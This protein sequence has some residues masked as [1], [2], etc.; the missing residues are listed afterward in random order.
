MS[1][2]PDF[3]PFLHLF[4]L[5]KLKIWLHEIN[6]WLVKND[7]KGQNLEKGK[8][9]CSIF[10]LQNFRSSETLKKQ[11][12]VLFKSIKFLIWLSRKCPKGWKTGH[13]TLKTYK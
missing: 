4:C 7:W 2:V 3:A 10:K 11:M 8:F 13:N 6:I 5:S 12:K 9:P 1:V